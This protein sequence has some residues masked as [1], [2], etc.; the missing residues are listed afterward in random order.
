MLINTPNANPVDIKY[1]A[2]DVEP[3]YLEDS[4][5]NGEDDLDY[6]EQAN[7]GMDSRMPLMVKTRKIVTNIWGR[8]YNVVEYHW[9]FIID[10]DNGQ[11]LDW[12]KGVKANIN[13]KVCDQGRYSFLDKDLEEIIGSDGTMYVPS[14]LD[15]TN[16]SFG[17]Y[18]DFTIDENGYIEEWN[19]LS[20]ETRKERAAKLW[21]QLS[22]ENE[23]DI[24]YR[25]GTC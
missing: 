25:N 2:C 7:Q 5:I 22:K 8:Q 19:L 20:E 3:R 12:T 16:D 14:L 13:Y 24:D 9:L 10:L 6:D 18:M 4:Q 11:V 21:K 23:E 1:L 17:D 15:F